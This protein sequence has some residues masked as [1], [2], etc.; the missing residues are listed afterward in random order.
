MTIKMEK[1]KFYEQDIAFLG[2]KLTTESLQADQE[3]VKIIL[4]YPA[5][6]NHKQLKG[7]IGL[8][9]A[10]NKFMNTHNL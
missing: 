5:P 10:Y 9:N 2:Y 4:E 7:F 1:L 6:K 8:A 3:E